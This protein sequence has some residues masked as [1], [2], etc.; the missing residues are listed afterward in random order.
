[1]HHEMNF[2]ALI[3]MGMVL[4]EWGSNLV[5]IFASHSSFAVQNRFTRFDNN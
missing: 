3:C 5:I 2:S 4:S 1:M